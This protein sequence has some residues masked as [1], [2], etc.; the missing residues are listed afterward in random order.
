M[1]T[2]NFSAVFDVPEHLLPTITIN[3]VVTIY[4][5]G[6]IGLNPSGNGVNLSVNLDVNSLTNSTLVDIVIVGTHR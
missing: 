3:N 4:F 1:S 2:V 5:H 6:F